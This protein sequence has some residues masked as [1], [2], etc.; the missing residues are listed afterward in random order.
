M[1]QQ[2]SMTLLDLNQ[3]A[4]LRAIEKSLRAM[5][6]ISVFHSANDF[7]LDAEDRK[8]LR[9]VLQDKLTVFDHGGHLG[10]LYR[11]DVQQKI[12]QKLIAE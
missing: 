3:K 9:D 1:Q 5:P 11:D 4:G 12:I 10:N 6:Q 7:L 8:F 2:E